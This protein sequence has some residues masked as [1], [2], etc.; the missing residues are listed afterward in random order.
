MI[1]DNNHGCTGQIPPGGV[2]PVL[3]CVP[4]TGWTDLYE[5]DTGF[6]R[7]TV[8]SQ[9]DKPFLGRYFDKTEGCANYRM[10][11]YR[12]FDMA[13]EEQTEEEDR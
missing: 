8:L 3:M 10:D 11:Q 7:G 9:L 1:N 12:F 2:A 13:D 4:D 5:P 6:G